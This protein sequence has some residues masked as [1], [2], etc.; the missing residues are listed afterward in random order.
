ML[1]QS[2][3]N[4]DEQAQ[5]FARADALFRE[6]SEQAQNARSAAQAAEELGVPQEYLDRA[7]AQI[8]AEKVENIRARRKKM[9]VG[10]GVGL[11][12]AVAFG[13]FS[14]RRPP[15]PTT[16]AIAPASVGQS[17][18]PET[19]ASVKATNGALTI[20]VDRFGPTSTGDFFANATLPAP[21]NLGRYN[22][23]SFSVS[24]S[25]GI[26]AVRL[27]FQADK[28]RWKSDSRPISGGRVS[29]DLRSMQRQER[30]GNSWRNVSYRTPDTVRELAFKVGET[31]NPPIPKDR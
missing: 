25:G 12:L 28:L 21:E 13:L 9:R 2:E 26:S 18:N 5:V 1:K 6:E 31:V 16:L 10:I 8:H 17:V 15:A 19:Q 4:P 22:K 23:V 20:Q 7:A 29:I 30:N 24:G 14:L 3:L 11:G 27:D